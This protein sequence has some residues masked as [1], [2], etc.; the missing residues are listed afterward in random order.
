MNVAFVQPGRTN[1]ASVQLRAGQGGL[2]R[3]WTAPPQARRSPA[4]GPPE[5]PRRQTPNQRH[6]RPACP[7]RS[8]SR[9]PRTGGTS[10][11]LASERR[12]GP[13]S[14]TPSA[15][16]SSRPDTPSQGVPMLSSTPARRATSAA[17]AAPAA[18]STHPGEHGDRGPRQPGKG[19]YLSRNCGG[20]TTAVHAA[21]R[22]D[23]RGAQPP[24]GGP[25]APR[26]VGLIGPR[27]RR[28][29]RRA[30]RS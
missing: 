26:K 21:R 11:A 17:G 20:P 18:A 23:G 10:P 25:T 13:P 2:K 27:S 19:W 8:P 15:A 4:G 24:G 1:V 16:R 14:L 7:A 3:D 9:P 29:H 22:R 6:T 28:A 5:A 12:A 30:V